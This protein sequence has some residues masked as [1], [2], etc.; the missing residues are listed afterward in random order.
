MRI[1]EALARKIRQV[2]RVVTLRG[3]FSWEM[4]TDPRTMTQKNKKKRHRYWRHAANSRRRG[5]FDEVLNRAARRLRRTNPSAARLLADYRRFDRLSHVDERLL[6]HRSRVERG[7]EPFRELILSLAAVPVRALAERGHLDQEIDDM[8]QEAIAEMMVYLGNIE[9]GNRSQWMTLVS[10]VPRNARYLHAV[11]M[12]TQTRLRRNSAMTTVLAKLTDFDRAE[13]EEMDD[14][15]LDQL[16]PRADRS[17]V[18]EAIAGLISETHE[19]A[20]EVGFDPTPSN[21]RAIDLGRVIAWAR[22]TFS[23]R[24]WRIFSLRYLRIEGWAFEDIGKEIGVSAERVR[25]IERDILKRLGTAYE[26]DL[27]PT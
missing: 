25:Q 23:E 16:F 18:K 5:D 20:P 10:F 27:A 8:V 4:L 22:K 3:P 12:A 1:F 15:D 24:E 14:R 6:L 21:D 26:A 19:P 13:L 9:I 2:D 17:V 11:H 7:A